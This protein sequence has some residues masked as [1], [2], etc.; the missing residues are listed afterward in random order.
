MQNQGHDARIRTRLPLRVDPFRNRRCVIVRCVLEHSSCCLDNDARAG[1]IRLSILAGVAWYLK[2]Y[3]MRVVDE[4]EA[5]LAL[6]LLV[7]SR[8]RHRSEGETGCHG[9]AEERLAFVCR[10]VFQRQDCAST[11]PHVGA[12][13][14]SALRR[15]HRSEALN[16]ILPVPAGVLGIADGGQHNHVSALVDAFRS[17]ASSDPC[18]SLECPRMATGVCLRAGSEGVAAHRLQ[19]AIV[20]V[21][22]ARVNLPVDQALV[23]RMFHRKSL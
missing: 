11:E 8:R 17:P 19:H 21:G 3:R 13:R 18:D 5:G 20:R 14:G 12:H 9:L 7:R 15:L 6:R 22:E 16:V 1:L 23:L 2:S 10:H 4:L